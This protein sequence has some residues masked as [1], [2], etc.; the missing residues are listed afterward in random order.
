M[1][2]EKGVAELREHV[3][4]LIVIPNQRLLEQAEE[5]ATMEGAFK[6]ADDVLRQGV[7]GISDIICLPGKVN[8]D[9]ADVRAVMADAGT[10]MLGMGM[11]DGANRSTEAALVR[12]PPSRVPLPV[13]LRCKPVLLCRHVLPGL[14]VVTIDDACPPP[15]WTLC[16]S[17][18]RG[19]T[20]ASAVPAGAAD[21]GTKRQGVPCRA[22]RR[23]R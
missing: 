11:A 6:L 22:Q 5:E 7:Q 15:P 23:R 1:Q 18:R 4:T 10:A 16:Q 12:T 8:V 21:A 14:L 17:T 9:F 20:R 13:V 19:R 2:A 3:D